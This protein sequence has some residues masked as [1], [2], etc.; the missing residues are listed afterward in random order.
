[1]AGKVRFVT[2][3]AACHGPEGKGNVAIG[4][5]NLT[6]NIWLYGSTLSDIKTSIRDGRSGKMPAWGPI[7][8]KDRARL[9]E[10]WVLAQGSS[11][12]TTAGQQ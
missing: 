1:E 2:I 8:G 10:A 6:D 7:I 5:P 12:E 3:C 11:A 4:A 9:V